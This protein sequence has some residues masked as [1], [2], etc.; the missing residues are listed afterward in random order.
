[1]HK[2]KPCSTQKHPDAHKAHKAQT[3][4]AF[5]LCKAIG[6]KSY[7]QP[8]AHKAHKA[9]TRRAQGAQTPRTTPAHNPCAQPC[10]QGGGLCA[11]LFVLRYNTVLFKYA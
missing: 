10:A 3:R 7:A 6:P 11:Q 1:M 4:E 8:R 5:G 9:Q 2:A